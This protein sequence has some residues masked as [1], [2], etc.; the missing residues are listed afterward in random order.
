MKGISPMKSGFRKQTLLLF[1]V[2]LGVML[3][4]Q[5]AASAPPLPNPVLYLIGT[6]AY[7]GGGKQ[8]IRYEYDV[9]NKD[10]YPA[11]MFA[12]APAL[13]PCGANTKSS[14]TWV[15]I[16]D[17]RGKRLY[18]FC[19]LGKPSDL[20]KIWFALETGVVPPS[21]VYIEMNDRQTNTKYKSNLADTTP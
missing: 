7:Q 16:F 12:A 11:E 15:D 8:F 3:S 18:G 20:S 4:T 17:S 5:P 9:L 19:A 1:P 21:Y 10:S 6:E 2:L 13:P 14:R